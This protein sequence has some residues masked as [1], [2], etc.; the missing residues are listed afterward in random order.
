MV[1]KDFPP[2]RFA[3]EPLVSPLGGLIYRLVILIF[4][5]VALDSGYAHICEHCEETETNTVRLAQD[6]YVWQRS[7]TDSVRNALAEHG[8]AFHRI[9]VLA[10]E[11]TWKN[12]EPHLVHVPIDFHALKAQNQPIGLAL[13][14]GP[15]TGPFSADHPST[16]FLAAL[17]RRLLVEARSNEVEI[18][19][20]QLDFDC[21]ESKLGGY[22]IWVQEIGH[23]IAPVP[24]I[25][26]ALPSWLRH[27]EFAALAK[28]AAGYVLQVHSL[29]KPKSAGD[30]FNLC[31]P[32]A[33]V[34]AVSRA[35][36]IGV[37]FRVALPTYG[38]LIAFD[39]KG[40]FIGLSAEGPAKPWPKDSIIREVQSDPIA[41]AGLVQRWTT[42]PPPNMQGLIW[43]RFPIANDNFNWRWPTLSAIMTARSPKESLRAEP[44]R[45]EPGLV[46]INLVND[47]ELDISSRLA[48][49]VRWSRVGE[50]RLVAGDGLGDFDIVEAD[51]STLRFQT[52]HGP[53]RLRAG[54]TQVIG[55][56]RLNQNREVQLEIKKL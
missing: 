19:E 6:A 42:N 29:E 28:S 17:G 11:V 30:S 21:A 45:V 49:E 1:M 20:L 40:Q 41:M 7:W 16:K 8:A 48:I 9:V 34:K 14:I 25:I 52:S 36:D 55:W 44:R 2:R 46:E 32:L 38:Y 26:T 12:Q 18:V 13:R 47:G 24:T 31:D 23:R 4:G 56:L 3:L 37:P 53:C 15:W 27:P 39:G 35:S 33:A 22:R 54:Q 10:A 5:S 50:V 43:Y 51:P